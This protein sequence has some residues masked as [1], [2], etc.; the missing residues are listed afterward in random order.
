MKKQRGITLIALV[1]TIIVLLIL[2]GVSIAM[3]TGDNGILN[4]AQT[5]GEKTKEAG[6]KEKVEIAVM[7]SYTEDGKISFSELKSNLENIDGIDK[8][9]IPETITE[10]NFN[11]TVKVDGYPVII[12]KNGEVVIEEK[13]GENSDIANIPEGY[14]KPSGTKII[15]TNGTYNVTSY[16]G[17]EVYVPTYEANSLLKITEK[18]S[19][20]DVSNYQ[21]VDTSSLFTEGEMSC[22]KFTQNFPTSGN[23]MTINLDYIPSFLFLKAT[24][25]DGNTLDFYSLDSCNTFYRVNRTTNEIGAVNSFKKVAGKIVF[26]VGNQPNW[27]GVLI[28]IFAIQ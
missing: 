6:A 19:K 28:E 16:E 5:A 26:T 2:A 3:L 27:K 7:G 25:N 8:D 9:T 17:V 20:I 14:I 1:I 23:T 21:Y 22:K 4:K 10:D 12:K 13:A 11:L 15:N 24:N 18:N